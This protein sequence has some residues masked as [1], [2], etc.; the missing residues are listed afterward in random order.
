MKGILYITIISLLVACSSTTVEKSPTI[1]PFVD[2]SV[3]G[4]LFPINGKIVYQ[5]F[6]GGFWSIVSDDGKGYEPLNFP[7][8]FKV[9]NLEVSIEAILRGDMGSHRFTGLVIEIRTMKQQ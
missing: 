3:S 9:D 2:E 7:D 5:T 8:R 1:E 4:P 6:E